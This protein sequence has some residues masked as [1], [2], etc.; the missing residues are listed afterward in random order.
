MH[1]TPEMTKFILN[2]KD[3]YMRGTAYFPDAYVSAM[4]EERYRRD[5]LQIK[6]SGFNMLRVH[7]HVDLPIFYE[8]CDELG[9]GIM[10][11]SEYNWM[12]PVDESICRPFYPYLSGNRRYAK[13]TSFSVLLDLYE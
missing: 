10:H 4:N 5:L 3:F 8:L 7:V 9:L 1:R 12:H 2:G 6:N 13:K 11:D